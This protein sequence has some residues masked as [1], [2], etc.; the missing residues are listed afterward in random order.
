MT[1]NPDDKIIRFLFSQPPLPQNE[2]FAETVMAKIGASEEKRAG[3]GW[4]IPVFGYGLVGLL[5]VLSFLSFN[6]PV[7]TTDLLS[8]NGSVSETVNVTQLLEP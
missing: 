8:T 4:A 3:W 7:S 1:D 2:D 5:L 6:D